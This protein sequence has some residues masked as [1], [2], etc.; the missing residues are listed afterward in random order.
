MRAL[1]SGTEAEILIAHPKRHFCRPPARR[2]IFKLIGGGSLVRTRRNVGFTLV[3][4]LVVIAIIGILIALLLPAVQA[5]REAARRA[6]CTNNLKNLGLAV[7]N[8]M[9]LFK[10]FPVSM[11]AASAPTGTAASGKGWIVSILPQIEQQALYDI[12]AKGPSGTT[13]D[14]FDTAFSVSSKT[15]MATTLGLTT[16]GVATPLEVLHCPSDSSVVTRD[17]QADWGASNNVAVTNYKGVLGISF[18][19]ATAG[20]PHAR[21]TQY[22]GWN[23]D[24]PTGAFTTDED[25]CTD[26]TTCMGAFWPRT[27]FSAVRESDFRDGLSNTLI[28]GED[29]PEINKSSS[30]YLSS[31]D[32]C[33]THGKI[34]YTPAS[35]DLPGKNE[36][37]PNVKTFRSRHASGAN[38][39]IGDGSVTF[40]SD[41]IDMKLYQYLA[42]RGRGEVAQLPQ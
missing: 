10:T 28:I 15:G 14:S 7:H 1:K 30:A 39:C 38:F 37:D 20:T 2:F 3:E 35:A 4:L 24:P 17:D 5:A 32:W 16:G 18:V 33:S 34:N 6:Q 41:S 31:H 36:D 26:D 25:N 40:I 9:T 27:A 11:P 8:Y 29:I 21:V 13:N 19:G 12:F 42:T 23:V 22:T